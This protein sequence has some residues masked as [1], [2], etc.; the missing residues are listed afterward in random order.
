MCFDGFI[1]LDRDTPSESGLYVTDLPGV[2]VAQLDGIT[3]DEQS[4]TEELFEN[5]Y[6]NAQI[7]LKIDIQRKLAP[8]RM[9][10]L[11]HSMVSAANAGQ[12]PVN[13]KL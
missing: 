5:I 1:T 4:D 8:I 6:R 7:N 10:P 2:T 3:K 12:D 13:S 9:S 11:R